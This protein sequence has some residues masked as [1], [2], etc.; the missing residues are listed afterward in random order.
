MKLEYPVCLALCL[1]AWGRPVTEASSPDTGTQGPG[2][3]PE[4]WVNPPP[5]GGRGS[6]NPEKQAFEP[7][8]MAPL[9][10][11]GED[12]ELV[13]RPFSERGDRIPDFSTVG[14]M[15][16]E[17]P[18][19]DVPVEVSLRPP[20][21]EAE[22]R[23]DLKYPVGP[24]SHA[25][26]QAALDEVAAMPPG[27]DGFRGAVLLE[28]GTWHLERP[29]RVRSGVVLR[30]EGDGESG[31]VLLCTAPGGKEI[32]IR[33]GGKDSGGGAT[34]GEAMAKSD[35]TDAYI[36]T[37]SFEVTVA[38]AGGFEVGDTVLVTK[39]TNRAWIDEL[40][41]GERLRH[42][43]GGKEGEKKRPWGTQAYRHRRTIVAIDGN[44]LTLDSP[45]IQS[46]A[47]EHGGGYVKEIP[48]DEDS[49]AAV[50]SLRIVS[51]Y[52]TTVRDTGKRAN[53]KNLASGIIVR[54]TNSW[55]RDVTVKHVW[56][57]AV[58][59]DEAHGI[60]VRDCASLEPVGPKRGGRRYTFS[61]KDSSGILVYNCM[62]EDGR[63]DFVIGSRTPGPNVFLNCTA[64]RGGQSEPHHRW[65]AGTLYDNVTMKDGGSLAAIN[66]G[67]S[68]SGH[69]WA[70]A[71]TVFWNCDAENI[72][73]ADPETAGE[74]NFAIGFTGTVKDGYDTGGLYYANTRA[75]YWGTSKEGKYYGFAIMGDGYIESPDA[76]VEPRSLFVKQLIDRIGIERAVE[77]L[78]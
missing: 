70:A 67:D 44:A 26:I 42:I 61:I 51:N 53:F 3:L 39:T 62:A 43:R 5:P 64:V 22:V 1:L 76:P 56:Q 54:A 74:N 20:V 4:S 34:A 16:S 65:G 48:N 28:T 46:I 78:E 13:Y 18:I 37:G 50:E 24:G 35:I 66:R 27:P 58:R 52:D 36:P 19:P 6:W 41:M 57:S 73:V 32:A 31:T 12:G 38:D 77:V 72:V 71:N 33:L 21:G 47:A 14:Y 49:L 7:S 23:G 2:G 29:L 40:G 63:H 59:M 75:G 9:V 25:T 8:P 11:I 45:M 30:G 60:T 17:V 10:S 69:G 68:G 55:V 15:R